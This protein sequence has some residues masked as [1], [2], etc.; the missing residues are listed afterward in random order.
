[1][2]SCW[3]RGH[4]TDAVSALVGLAR[5]VERLK[6]IIAHTPLDRPA[7]GRVLA[8][9]GFVS[10]GEVEDEHEGEIVRVCRWEFGPL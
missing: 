8:K 6:R 10:T 3:G 5:E 4:A 2:E 9:A 7:S 1:V